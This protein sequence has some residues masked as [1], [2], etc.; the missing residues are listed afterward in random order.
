MGLSVVFGSGA[1]QLLQVS[2]STALLLLLLLLV[3]TTVPPGSVSQGVFTTGAPQ[4]HGH[5]TE[6]CSLDT[7]A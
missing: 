5:I 6:N 3:E 7:T 4:I 1:A 2:W